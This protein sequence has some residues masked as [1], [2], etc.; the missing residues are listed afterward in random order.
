MSPIALLRLE[1]LPVLLNDILD[2]EES[3]LR[4]IA[5]FVY[6]LNSYSGAAQQALLLAKTVDLPIVIFNHENGK[7]NNVNCNEKITIITLPSSNL[8]KLFCIVFYTMRMN[9]KIYHHH[10]FFKH[11]LLLGRL[12]GRVNILKTTLMKSD[13]FETLHKTFKSKLLFKLLI[14]CVD[15]N[16]CLTRLLKEKNQIFLSEEKIVVIP[17]M[18][19]CSSRPTL[20]KKEN[21]FCFVGLV[22]ARKRAYESIKYF[23]EHYAMLPGAMMY[24][25]GPLV[26]DKEGNLEYVEACKDLVKNFNATEQV[27]F[28]GRVAKE[29]VLDFYYRSK[30]LIFFSENEGMPNVML[31]AMAHNCAPITTGIGGIAQEILGGLGKDLIV[32]DP[33][34]SVP[35]N[36]IDTLL[37]NKRLENKIKELFSGEVISEL[38]RRC[39]RNYLDFK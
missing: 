31:E 39:Y 2:L 21:I 19:D 1:C 33:R 29:E 37:E 26:G 10:G 7:Y 20:T 12:L 38:Y 3:L 35:M 18:A 5:Y 16:V 14:G 30:A 13:D 36:T 17:N 6:N 27:I 25:V 9:V 28:T 34:V 32:E 24:V 11:G 23:L 8:L 4:M 22:C 15:L